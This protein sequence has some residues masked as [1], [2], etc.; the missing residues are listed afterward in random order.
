MVLAHLLLLNVVDVRPTVNVVVPLVDART[1]SVLE[2]K[3]TKRVTST[4]TVLGALADPT[5]CGI[6]IL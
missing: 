1:V 4:P 3:A 5:A 2:W 6:P